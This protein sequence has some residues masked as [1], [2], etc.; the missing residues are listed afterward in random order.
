MPYTMLAMSWHGIYG[1]LAAYGDVYPGAP[2]PSAC[3]S[4]S[5]C[6]ELFAAVFQRF[7]VRP[8]RVQ[9]G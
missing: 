2:G 7:G 6:I 9:R 4:I 8:P 1:R 5:P 3:A